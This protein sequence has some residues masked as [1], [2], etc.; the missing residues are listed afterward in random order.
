MLGVNSHATQVPFKTFIKMCKDF[1]ISSCIASHQELSRMF[2]A[3]VQTNEE[4]NGE[5]WKELI[6]RCAMHWGGL[7]IGGASPMEIADRVG[8]FIQTL[9]NSE[10]MISVEQWKLRTQ[11]HKKAL[12]RYAPCILD[13]ILKQMVLYRFND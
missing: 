11:T 2:H 5:Q 10:A 9:E 1:G 8:K 3:T 13:T 4:A 6:C 12:Y 7:S